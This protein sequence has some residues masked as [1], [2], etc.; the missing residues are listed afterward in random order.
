MAHVH[1]NGNGF[2]R[3]FVPLINMHVGAADCRLLYLDENIVFVNFGFGHVLQP[4][5]SFAL[6][7]NQCFHVAQSIL[8]P[9]FTGKSYSEI[10]PNSHP[11]SPTMAAVSFS[12]YSSKAFRSSARRAGPVA[13]AISSS[14][15]RP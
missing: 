15:A 12:Q 10:C 6:F 1:G 3:P 13:G 14:K 4:Q 11:T 2:L 9:F 7:F 8:P 5:P